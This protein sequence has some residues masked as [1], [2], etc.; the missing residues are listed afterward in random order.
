[1]S[2][3]I[4]IQ[5]VRGFI[6][7]DGTAQLN[8]EDVSRGLGFTTEVNGS[9]YV[10]WSRVREHLEEFKFLPQV[11]KEELTAMQVKAITP[12]FIPENIFYR[13]AMKAKNETA[14]RFQAKVCDEILPSIR[15]TGT[16][17]VQP[18]NAL[19]ALQQTVKV[20]TDH[21]NRINQLDEKIDNEIRLT[22][23]QQAEVQFAISRRVVELLGGKD[24]ADYR[25][26]KGSYFSQLHRDLK[27]RLGVP[28]YRDI[29]RLDFDNAIAYIRAWLPK[30]QK[31][32]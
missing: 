27:E 22:Y 30:V 3:L 12:D 5:N 23:N 20:L 16:Y 6:D 11:A 32:A 9:E 8:L 10:R 21:E 4:T 26:L 31:S 13:L 7:E 25:N 2:N 15:K 24:T 29:R 17:S 1:V 28:S 18:A 14:E 19:E